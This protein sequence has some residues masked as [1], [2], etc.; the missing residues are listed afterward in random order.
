MDELENGFPPTSSE[1]KL[2]TCRR[3]GSFTKLETTSYTLR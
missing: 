1:W 2:K 3:W